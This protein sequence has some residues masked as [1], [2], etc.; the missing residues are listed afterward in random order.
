MTESTP[1]SKNEVSKSD[2]NEYFERL[3]PTYLE[4]QYKRLGQIEEHGLAVSG[5][6][7]A[8]SVAVLTFLARWSVP[9]TGNQAVMNLSQQRNILLL[10][11]IVNFAAIVYVGRVYDAQNMHDNR[12]NDI[13]TR[14]ASALRSVNASPGRH[15][16]WRIRLI[17]QALVHV[18]VMII[19][20]NAYLQ[21]LT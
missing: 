21:A 8:L 6:V 1:G 15:F 16:K 14:Y 10:I 13:L 20:S 3:L 9:L 19:I 2:N 17:I 7:L 18:L 5:A 12:A 11:F 4:W